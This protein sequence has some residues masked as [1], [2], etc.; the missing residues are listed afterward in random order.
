MKE[1]IYECQRCGA[2]LERHQQGKVTWCSRCQ[3]T[4][5]MGFWSGIKA[6][7]KVMDLVDSYDIEAM[8]HD[9]GLLPFVVKE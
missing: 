5:G 7:N 9:E 8:M 1:P 2:T 4:W 3:E 6:H